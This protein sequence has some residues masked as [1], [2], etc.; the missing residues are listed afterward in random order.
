MESILVCRVLIAVATWV[1]K[2]L[3][4]SMVSAEVPIVA[5]IAAASVVTVTPDGKSV[6]VPVA[7]ADGIV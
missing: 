2:L 4:L 7:S 5:A 6:I 1:L 3:K